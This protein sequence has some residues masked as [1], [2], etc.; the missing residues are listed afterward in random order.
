MLL[1]EAIF[2]YK[3]LVTRQG[4]SLYNVSYHWVEQGSCVIARESIIDALF[5][6]VL[7]LDSSS[8]LVASYFFFFFSRFFFFTKPFTLRWRLIYWYI[9]CPGDAI[10]SNVSLYAIQGVAI[11]I[12]DIERE[13]IMRST[14]KY[15][16][17]GVM[18]SS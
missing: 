14:L 13:K 7:L 1:C 17:A 3:W 9:D 4:Y 12:V 18:S 5:S 16:M 8:L 2:N 11:L 15:S 6:L 10:V